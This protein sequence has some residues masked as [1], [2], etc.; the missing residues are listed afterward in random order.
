MIVRDISFRT[1]QENILF[2]DVLFSLAEQGFCPQ[3]LRFWESQKSFIVLGK[4]SKPEDD[5]NI[6]QVCKDNIPILRRS[7]GGGTVLLGKGC[8]NYSLIMSKE[9]RPQL[10]AIHSS[11][12][13]ILKKITRALEPFGIFSVFKPIS[14]IALAGSEK[15]FSGNAQRRAKKFILHHG[16]ILYDFC[17]SD[18]ERYLSIPKKIPEYRNELNQE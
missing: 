8:L 14:D 11:Y 9:I 16:T 12:D 2:D 6:E 15:K 17:I 5:I 13:Y 3:T 1:P 4:I 10:R 18:V 7:S